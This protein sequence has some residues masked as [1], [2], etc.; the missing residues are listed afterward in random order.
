[1]KQ[2]LER[3]EINICEWKKSLHFNVIILSHIFIHKSL[4]RF[5]FV[6]PKKR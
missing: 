6:W 4:Y 1:M 3:I 5:D 2:R